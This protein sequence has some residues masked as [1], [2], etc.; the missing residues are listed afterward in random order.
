MPEWAEKRK[1]M[2]YLQQILVVLGIALIAAIIATNT[3]NGVKTALGSK[4]AWV[5]RVIAVAV[6]I[7]IS[8]WVYFGIA[9]LNDYLTYV[10]ILVLVYAGAQTIYSILGELTEAKKKM[11]EITAEIGEVQGQSSEADSTKADDLK[12]QG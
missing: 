7:L 10:V 9:K 1:T 5:N 4:T 3:I 12:G 6:D 8:I 11:D 2:E